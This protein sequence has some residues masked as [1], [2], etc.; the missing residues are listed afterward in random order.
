MM[1]AQ[2]GL[3]A[4][5][6]GFFTADHRACD[7]LWATVESAALARDK[8]AAE[9]A[10]A[11]FDT[12]TRRHLDMEEQVLFPALEAALG[13]PWVPLQMMR[14][15]HRQ[16]RALLAQM[17]TSVADLPALLEQGDTLLMFTQQHNMKEE[18]VVYPMTGRLDAHWP[19]LVQELAPWLS[20]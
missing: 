5:A 9:V 17:A 7:D 2:V 15:E 14:S 4:G 8:A 18:G 20:R 19:Q 11:A 6:I 3:E 12:A 10:F 16:M 1:S 13:G